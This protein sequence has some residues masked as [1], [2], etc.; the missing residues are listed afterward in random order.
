MHET[1][2]LPP[3]TTEFVPQLVREGACICWSAR[4]LSVP[5]PL[6]DIRFQ[7]DRLFTWATIQT[8]FGSERPLFGVIQYAE[9]RR[10]GGGSTFWDAAGHAVCAIFPNYNF[11]FPAYTEA[12]L[13]TKTQSHHTRLSQDR[14]YA[15]EWDEYFALGTS[16]CL[17]YADNAFRNEPG[18]A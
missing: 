16:Q 17:S 11:G 14:A 8:P 6:I 12:K 18:N 4:I 15:A 9:Q 7:A 1:T 13:R 2:D 5:I 3:A 10:E